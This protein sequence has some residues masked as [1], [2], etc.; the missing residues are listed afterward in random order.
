MNEH[1]N[2][3]FNI[4]Q[5]ESNKPEFV[6][7]DGQRL[8]GGYRAPGAKVVSVRMSRAAAIS[9]ADLLQKIAD[10]GRNVESWFQTLP[11][12]D[13]DKMRSPRDMVAKPASNHER[14][15][16]GRIALDKYAVETC[17]VGE[18][19]DQTILTNLLTDLMHLAD[20]DGLNWMDAI[21]HAVEHFN[22][23]SSQENES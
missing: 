17:A 14:A 2:P 15:N 7:I 23:E 5:A 13:V 22:F 3:R 20:R 10:E 18:D 21:A 16:E 11:R 6:V 19:A 4:V 1:N 9:S 8:P 12:Y